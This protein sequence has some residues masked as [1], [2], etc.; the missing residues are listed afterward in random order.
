VKVQGREGKRRENEKKRSTGVGKKRGNGGGRGKIAAKR[1][2]AKKK[3]GPS[4]LHG[5]KKVD[6]KTGS[7]R[8]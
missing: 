4:G 5:S 7:A 2:S 3:K 1:P 6:H 8:F